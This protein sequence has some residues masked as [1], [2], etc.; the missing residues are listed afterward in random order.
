MT[1][2]RPTAPAAVGAAGALPWGKAAM[3]LLLGLMAIKLLALWID[4]TLRFFM[5]DSGSYLHSA[6]TGWRPPDRSYTYGQLVAASALAAGSP[7][8][9]LALQAAFG[10]ASAMAL[11]ALLV[12]GCGVR[13]ALAVGAALLLAIEPAQ[14]F[15][16]RMLMAESAGT[17]AFVLHVGLLAA[18]ARDG[19]YRWMGLAAIAGLA[20]ISLRLSLLP[21]VLGLSATVPVV[22]ALQE[23]ERGRR[24][25][26]IARH[27]GFALLVTAALHAAYQ[28]GYRRDYG[29][30]TYLPANG[31][32]RIGL[33]APLVRAEHFEGT[34]VDGAI[35]LAELG[36][37]LTDAGRR[38]AHVW[39]SDGLY[40]TLSRHTD[41]PEQVARVVTGRAL[42][43]SPLGWLRLGVENVGGYFS[44][45]ALPFRLEDDLGRRPPDEGMLD[46]LQAR[47]GYDARGVAASSSL[48]TRWFESGA[49]WLVACFLLL[50]PLALLALALHWR[51]PHRAVVA[52]ICLASL[53]LVSGHLLFAHI[54]SLRYLHPMPW[55]VLANA[56]LVADALLR[57]RQV[58]GPGTAR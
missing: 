34:G 11:A 58:Q 54:A 8:A 18:Y 40:Q 36:Q 33:V 20:A 55:F 39:A 46:V 31:M 21:V 9:L 10:I 7:L 53:G 13:P 28:A 51:G 17:L 12:R 43:D 6:L 47:L 37:S 45:G 16:E 22:A 44:P 1:S 19:G 41:R 52:V 26:A 29:E 30:T 35:V 25:A 38:E 15:Y 49:P 42:R 32:M 24:L 56:A 2:L 5:G 3:A 23:G 57:R 48:A 50:A 27:L 4:P 14:L